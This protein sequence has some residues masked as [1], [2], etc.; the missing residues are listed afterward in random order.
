MRIGRAYAEKKD[1]D[2]AMEWIAKSAVAGFRFPNGILADADLAE[3]RADPRFVPILAQLNRNARPCES[4]PGYRSF[5]FWIGEWKLIT[6]AASPSGPKAESSTESPIPA[7]SQNM[8]ANFAM[9]LC[10]L[11]WSSQPRPPAP[12][13]IRRRGHDLDDHLR[14]NLLK[15]EVSPQ[16]LYKLTC[17]IT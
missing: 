12:R 17:G 11:W 9:A 5:N 16:G 1:L 4:T 15:V 14:R 3:L 8:R 7:S 6:L 10:D 13:T 2:H